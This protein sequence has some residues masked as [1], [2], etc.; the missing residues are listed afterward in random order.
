VLRHLAHATLLSGFVVL[1]TAS[2][3]CGSDDA[4]CTSLCEVQDKTEG[5]VCSESSASTCID[6]CNDQ[7]G[8][9]ETVC[10][11]CLLEGAEFKPDAVTGD[12]EDECKSDTNCL[13]GF[14]CVAARNGQTC[15]YCEGDVMGKEKCDAQLNPRRE[16]ECKAKFNDTANCAAQCG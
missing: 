8:G 6:A 3:A 16:V 2:Y 7:I 1:A 9:V 14:G 4:R 12:G 5:D 10:A 11:N 15:N 13:S